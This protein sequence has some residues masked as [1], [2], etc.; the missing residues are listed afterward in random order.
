[1]STERSASQS[2]ESSLTLSIQVKI[3][4]SIASAPCNLD[5]YSVLFS[6]LRLIT[7]FSQIL[8]SITAMKQITTFQ[9]DVSENEFIHSRAVSLQYPVRRVSTQ[10]HPL[11]CTSLHDTQSAQILAR[12]VKTHVQSTA[13]SKTRQMSADLRRLH[14]MSLDATL[15]LLTAAGI[16]CSL[17]PYTLFSQRPHPYLT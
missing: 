16:L 15:G 13:I 17:N 7:L 14:T 6:A 4:S 10:C 11:P 8:C 5:G 3:Q 12:I 9:K 1:M 2:M